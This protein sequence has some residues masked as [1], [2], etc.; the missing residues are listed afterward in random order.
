MALRRW[1]WAASGG[2]AAVGLVALVAG[3]LAG[4]QSLR[5][6]PPEGL[7][8]AWDAVRAV[9]RDFVQLG[10]EIDTVRA[11]DLALIDPFT[12]ATTALHDSC[13]V[14][15][16][17]GPE[18]FGGVGPFDEL[19]ALCRATPS[20]ADSFVTEWVGLAIFYRRI[21]A[22][23]RD[24]ATRLAGRAAPGDLAR[25]GQF[26]AL[27]HRETVLDPRAVAEILRE[28]RELRRVS[29][30]AGLYLETDAF[31]DVVDRY[32]ER[33][34]QAERLHREV[35]TS[36]F[37]PRLRDAQARLDA[38]L[39]TWETD[40]TWRLRFAV[41]GACIGLLFCVAALWCA[42]RARRSFP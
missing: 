42:G 3:C 34:P 29:D 9:D 23:A 1:W 12:K 22:D 40:R 21:V 18:F 19:V 38:H 31:F 16:R 2:A 39:A 10:E 5:V 33:R 11:A 20:R 7:S 36:D 32:L 30:Q 28:R 25:F 27:L 14:L 4:W 17:Q 24:Y 15:G 35:L 13:R 8:S 37:G 26:A 41:A 6:T